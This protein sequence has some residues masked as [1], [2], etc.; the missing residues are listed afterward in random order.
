MKGIMTMTEIEYQEGRFFLKKLITQTA[1]D[2]PEI[3][4]INWY[5]GYFE[6][7]LQQHIEFTN[8]GICR[9]RSL[10]KENA[11]QVEEYCNYCRAK[12]IFRL[13]FSDLEMHK[14]LCKTNKEMHDFNLNIILKK[15]GQAASCFKENSFI[16]PYSLN[17]FCCNCEEKH[18]YLFKFK[19]D[20]EFSDKEQ[21][22]TSKCSVT[23]IAQY[24]YSIK[25]DFH[26]LLK[27]NNK[28]IEAYRK[29]LINA[30]KAFCENMSAAAFLYLRRVFEALINK[31]YKQLAEVKENAKFGEKLKAVDGVLHIFPE[32]LSHNRNKV[33]NLLSEEI[34][35][36]MENYKEKD[37]KEMYCLLRGIIVRILEKWSEKKELKDQ[38]KKLQNY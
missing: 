9:P 27:F 38:N 10:F 35:S 18:V 24:P 31:E 28:T 29:E 17:T 13:N 15:N 6:S 4:D 32:E 34:H 12:K 23:K 20:L 7:E 26:E 25:N 37:W 8:T 3:F 30:E 2:Q 1:K 21:I 11:L 22:Y 5:I 19:V 33:Y 16:Y 36:S 14:F